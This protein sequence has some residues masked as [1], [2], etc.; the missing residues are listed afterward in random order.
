M[1]VSYRLVRRGPVFAALYVFL[2]LGF[3]Y[4]QRAD[5]ANWL[6]FFVKTGLIPILVAALL[7]KVKLTGPPRLR[8]IQGCS[9]Q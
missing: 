3:V 6:A 2:A 9:H 4:A 7:M 5:F 1:G 8:A